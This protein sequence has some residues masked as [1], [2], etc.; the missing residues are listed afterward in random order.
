M[1]E[2]KIPNTSIN[3][4]I[5]GESKYGSNNRPSEKIVPVVVFVD[6]EAACDQHGSEN[7]RVGDY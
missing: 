5:R 6:G 1:I 4:P 3:H 2:A 7:G